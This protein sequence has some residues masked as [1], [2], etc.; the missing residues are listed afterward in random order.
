MKSI[1]DYFKDNAYSNL[2]WY[3]HSTSDT[4]LDPTVTDVSAEGMFSFEHLK[5]S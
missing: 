4:R 2:R 3:F 5:E 1:A